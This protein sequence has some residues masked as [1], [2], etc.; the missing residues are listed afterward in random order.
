[1]ATLQCGKHKD[2]PDC[3]HLPKRTR[4]PVALHSPQHSPQPVPFPVTQGALHWTQPII[5]VLLLAGD[6]ISQG[7]ATS[8]WPMREER[9]SAKGFLGMVFFTLKKGQKPSFLSCRCMTAGS[10]MHALGMAEQKDRPKV[11]SDISD[12]SVSWSWDC[13]AS[14]ITWDYNKR[15]FWGSNSVTC[16]Q[17]PSTW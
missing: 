6:W 9:K 12:P 3:Q 11:F 10:E 1:M 7:Q 13:S 4:H 15:P 8:S 2:S 14:F 16:S 17:K 5:M